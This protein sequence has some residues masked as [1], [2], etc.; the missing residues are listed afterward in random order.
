MLSMPASSVIWST[1]S[2]LKCRNVPNTS[3]AKMPATAKAMVIAV[4]KDKEDTTRQAE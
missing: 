4:N 2:R 1:R 3:A